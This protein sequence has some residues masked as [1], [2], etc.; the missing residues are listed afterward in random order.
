MF[1]GLASDYL[2]GY[3]GYNGQNNTIDEQNWG[4]GK[5]TSGKYDTAQNGWKVF[6]GQG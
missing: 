2:Q 1:S 3:P 4:G 6:G 5:P